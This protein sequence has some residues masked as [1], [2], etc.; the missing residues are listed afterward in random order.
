M[1]FHWL[2]VLIALA[3]V[4]VFYGGLLYLYWSVDILLQP[5]RHKKWEKRLMWTI[6]AL[7][8]ITTLISIGFIS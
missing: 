8:F 3:V 4:A 1:T 6:L 5:S 7:F 2:N